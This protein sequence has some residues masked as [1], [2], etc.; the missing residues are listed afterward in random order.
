MANETDSKTTPRKLSS[1]MVPAAVQKNYGAALEYLQKSNFTELESAYI[2]AVIESAHKIS[3]NK[4]VQFE[5]PDLQETLRDRKLPST[6][7]TVLSRANSLTQMGIFASREIFQDGGGRPYKQYTLG[8]IHHKDFKSNLD[9]ESERLMAGRMINLY[10]STRSVIKRLKESGA[11]F[12]REVGRGKPRTD[13][14]FCGLLDRAMR[15]TTNEKIDGNRITTSV[16][17]K[18]CRLIVQ[19]T[20][21]TKKGSEIAALP[22]QRVMRAVITEVA[23]IIESTI[24]D[25][26]LEATQACQESF[27]FEASEIEYSEEG[28]PVI[29]R[30]NDEVT[31]DMAIQRIQN[32]FF[33]DV[34]SLASRMEYANPSSSS[35]RKVVN[36]SLRRLHETNFQI[37]V[38]NPES[39][40]AIEV[41]RI[42]DLDDSTTEFRF[43]SSLRSQYDP[44]FY[45]EHFNNESGTQS[46]LMDSSSLADAEQTVEERNERDLSRIRLWKIALDPYL[47]NK[48]L[49]KEMRKLFAAHNEI[50]RESSGLAQTLYNFMTQ[51]IGRSDKVFNQSL[52]ILH[53][54]L[55]G[56]RQYTQFERD[57]VRLLK[58]HANKETWDASLR[59]NVVTMF[60]YIFTL[61]K[62][63]SDEMILNVRRDPADELNGD[64]SAYR[65]RLANEMKQKE[66]ASAVIDAS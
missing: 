54:T 31:D 36:A 16:N 39:N 37:I 4:E 50:L 13:S 66:A 43:I 45:E 30:Q 52:S 55:W 62:S 49:D 25:Y 35:T 7:Q 38:T 3:P 17:V 14:L 32:N 21:L 10:S 61:R 48:M 60:G 12:I 11:Q 19:A 46:D 8:N 44:S 53:K 20:T 41:M 64:N 40:E 2:K 22:D 9:L 26:M 34:V 33:I 23:S 42:F 65:R 59:L 6:R 1:F 27:I 56:Q 58:K 15:F 63:G 57:L 18:S 28:E 29:T 24:D 5:Y 51:V 47:F